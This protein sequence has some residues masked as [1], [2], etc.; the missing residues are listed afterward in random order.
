MNINKYN[1]D[2]IF[3]R[4]KSVPKL[5]V[6]DLGAD[7]NRNALTNTVPNPDISILTQY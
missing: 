1:L 2:E 7:F 3:V 4:Y 5:S 6:A